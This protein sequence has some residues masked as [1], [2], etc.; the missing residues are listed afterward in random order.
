MKL[1]GKI[2]CVGLPEISDYTYSILIVGGFR[3][4]KTNALFNDQENDVII[5]K[6]FLYAEDLHNS[7]YQ[8]QTNR[9]RGIG[10][11]HLKNP[12]IFMEYSNDLNLVCSIITGYSPRNKPKV[13]KTFNDM[14]ADMI[15]NKKLDSVVTELFFRGRK[16]NI[17][18]MYIIY[19]FILNIPNKWQ[20]QKITTNNLSDI[21]S[22]KLKRLYR[23]FNAEPYSFLA[24]DTTL[25]SENTLHFQKESIA[26]SIVSSY[27]HQLYYID[28][29]IYRAAAKISALSSSKIDKYEYLKYCPHNMIE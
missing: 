15:S 25:P 20:F 23:N 7:K 5:D 6:I 4:T 22:D 12:K 16:L 3:Q 10:L 8:L 28:I 27:D 18:L 9:C 13:L 11:K 19:F 26:M 24:I 29:Y 14:I 1:Q 17:S 2:N 21:D